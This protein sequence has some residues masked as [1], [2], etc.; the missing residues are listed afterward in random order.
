MPSFHDCCK[1]PSESCNGN[2]D[3]GMHAASDAPMA[4]ALLKNSEEACSQ[5]SRRDAALTLSSGN[6]S[7]AYLADQTVWF[8]VCAPRPSFGRTIDT[9]IS[10]GRPSGSLTAVEGPS[11]FV[12]FR[13]GTSVTPFGAQ[14]RSAVMS[15][16]KSLPV[17]SGVSPSSP[18]VP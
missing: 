1:R 6:S 3:S 12:S 15:S 14:T 2:R 13:L 7:M 17:S 4:K 16:A 5:R 9:A 18:S 11:V 10:H 8:T